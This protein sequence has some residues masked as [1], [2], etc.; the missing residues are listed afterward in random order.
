[1]IAYKRD[2]SV[3]DGCIQKPKEGLNMKYFVLNPT[4]NT[5]YGLA[6][7]MAIREYA[8]E[9]QKTNKKLANDLCNWMDILP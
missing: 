4:K 6:S 9:I 5:A 2:H 3:M 8:K 7:R 1:M